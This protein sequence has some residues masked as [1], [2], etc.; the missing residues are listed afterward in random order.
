MKNI[1]IS[2]FLII[3]FLFSCKNNTSQDA[4]IKGDN[5]VEVVS[6]SDFNA[7]MNNTNVQ[8]I[9]VRTPKEYNAGHL[10]KAKNINFFES[11]FITKMEELDKSKP[12]Y[13]YCRSDKRS[14]RAAAILRSAGFKK[15]Y[16]LDGGFLAWSKEKLQI[17]K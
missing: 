13:L 7:K 2:L 14:G 8:L 17:E 10:T 16:D 15:I 1:S 6:P 12:V 4:N 3:I 9:D 11:D 5:T